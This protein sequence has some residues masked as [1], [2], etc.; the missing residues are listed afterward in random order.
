M[1]YLPGQTFKVTLHFLLKNR[2]EAEKNELYISQN[3]V[4][5]TTNSNRPYNYIIS[6]FQKIIPKSKSKYHVSSIN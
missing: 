5:T 3:I 6:L 2:S 1:I 4:L